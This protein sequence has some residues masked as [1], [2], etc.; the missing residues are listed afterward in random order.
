METR[1]EHVI[2][3]PAAAAAIVVAMRPLTGRAPFLFPNARNPAAPMV[4]NG[5]LHMLERCGYGGI[6]CAH[7][8]RA[9][10]SS[11]MN[12]RHPDAHDAI[13]AQLAHVVRGV[14]GAYLR[15]PFLERRRAR[16]LSQKHACPKQSGA[17]A[18]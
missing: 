6:H 11:I 9:A 18:V 5:L 17:G 4:R 13:E 15:A 3:L 10:F 12:E 7:G 16:L 8:F 14:R 1:I 2:P